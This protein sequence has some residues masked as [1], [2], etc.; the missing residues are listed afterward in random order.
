MEALGR[1]LIA[2][3]EEVFLES[4]ADL[5]REEGYQCDCVADAPSAAR[6]LREGRYDVLIADIKMPGN[7]NLEL[8]RQVR[9]M[10]GGLPVILVTGYP[11]M[12][13]AIQSVGLPVLAYLVKP[14]DFNELKSS[15]RTA[16]ERS[17]IYD[18]VKEARA[19]LEEWR[20]RLAGM[21][22]LLRQGP[23]ADTPVSVE[24][25]VSVTMQNILMSLTCLK[26]VTEGV[27]RLGGEQNV[28]GL[29]DCPRLDKLTAATRD[30]IEVLEKTKN[31]FKSKELGGLRRRLEELVEPG[32]SGKD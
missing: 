11:S 16:V 28:C 7:P 23:E 19:R 27:A 13:S 14:V 29:V 6:K 18:A 2:D 12:E 26:D 32:G 4:T 31:A 1:I 30:A 8:V 15:V 10:P 17:R 24:T 22:E 21:Q 9:E 3:D 20:D 25:F 5:L